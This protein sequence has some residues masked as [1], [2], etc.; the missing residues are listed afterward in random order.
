MQPYFMPYAGYFR[1]LAVADIFVAF[2]CVQFPRRGWVHRNRLSDSAGTEKWL[3]LP[4]LKSDRDSTRIC[5]LCFRKEAQEEWLAEIM[6]FPSLV[7]L[8]KRG[9]DLAKISFELSD[10]PV[11][12]II[13]GLQWSAR[14]LGLDRPIVRSSDLAIEP[15]LKAQERIIEVVRR[16]GGHEYINAPGGRAI[17]SKE[18]FDAAGIK[19]HFL[20]DYVGKFSSVLERFVFESPDTIRAEI[21]RNLQLD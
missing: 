12:Y 15:T 6:R 10:R 2:D 7:D 16:V 9:G 5:D 11:D 4:L 14:T 8:R 20:S 3:T 19:L 13:R 17:Y 18:A 21:E 1:L